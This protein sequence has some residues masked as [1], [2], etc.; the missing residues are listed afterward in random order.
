[1]PGVTTG[2]GKDPDNARINGGMYDGGDEAIL[3][4]VSLAE[5][6]HESKRHADFQLSL[7]MV[8]E[9]KVLFNN[10]AGWRLPL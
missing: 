1:M 5:G 7:D 10:H 2:P 9:V 4:G 3:D 8:S 6:S